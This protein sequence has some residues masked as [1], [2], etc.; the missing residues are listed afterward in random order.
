[1]TSRRRDPASPGRFILASASPRRA[2]LLR[3]AGVEFEVAVADV[4]ETHGAGEPADV[5][6]ARLA[7]AKATAVQRRIPP[8]TVIGADT[9][10]VVGSQ[11]FG[12]PADAVDAM[13]MLRALSGRIH[14]VLTGV[15]VVHPDRAAVTDVATTIVEFA[16]LNDDELQ[17][18]VES[19]E[20]LDKA[21]AYAIQGLGSRFVTRIDG[22]Y[23]N[24]VGL[25]VAMVYQ[26]LKGRPEGRP[27][28]PGF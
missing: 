14:Q 3:A 22:S 27:L 1:M 10:V 2:E 18:Y 8:G 21:G 17:W 9:A 28:P 11:V 12:K 15:A 26:M 20:P 25:P 6:V 5:Y 13:R 23:S 4:D 16:Q 19:G 7:V 24:V